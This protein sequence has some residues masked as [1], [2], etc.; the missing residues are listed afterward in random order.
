[1]VA[2]MKYAGLVKQSLLDYPGEIAAV[3]FTRGCN[4]RCPFCHNPQLLYFRRDKITNGLAGKNRE[5]LLSQDYDAI[6]I[7]DLLSL[8]Q[9]RK[10]FL[11]A[12]V[13]SGGEP[14]LH[15]ELIDDLR[16]IKELAYL[17]KL[18]T[19]GSNPLMLETLLEEGLLDYVAMDIKAPLT[20]KQ[21]LP[22]VG[23]LSHQEFLVIRNSVYLLKEANIKVEFRTTVVPVLHNLED[24][25]EI[26]RHIEGAELY[27]LQ[28][29]NPTCTLSPA[30][31][32]VAPYNKEEMQE[33][34]DQCL[35]FVKNVRVINV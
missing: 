8:L 29:F 24:I 2:K 22:A 32:K 25:V 10:G 35:S 27:S 30:Y 18:D 15:H 12:V 6:D 9:E 11:D 26:A 1:M 21:Y 28:Q 4:L 5:D 19:N 23:K 20:Y 14:T 31:E 13:V 16:R 34:A 33:I 17:I 7:E 3:V